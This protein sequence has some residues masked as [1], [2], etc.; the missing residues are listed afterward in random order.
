MSFILAGIIGKVGAGEGGRAAED[1]GVAEGGTV[2]DAFEQPVAGIDFF[3]GA[4][5]RVPR[6]RFSA[7]FTKSQSW[8]NWQRIVVN[9]GTS[10][11][12]MRYC[13]YVVH[14]PLCIHR[15]MLYIFQFCIIL[16]STDSFLIQFAAVVVFAVAFMMAWRTEGRAPR[17]SGFLSA[18]F[19]RS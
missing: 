5:F 11:R 15:F 6:E 9:D 7:E 13:P 1:E 18:I 17:S 19:F 14:C 16:G 10:D 4:D 2:K 3:D 8:D 12:L